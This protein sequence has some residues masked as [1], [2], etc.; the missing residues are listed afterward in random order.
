MSVPRGKIIDPNDNKRH[1]SSSSKASNINVTID[2]FLN[3]LLF[4]EPIPTIETL[5]VLFEFMLEEPCKVTALLKEPERI[6]TGLFC[7]NLIEGDSD[8]EDY[9]KPRIKNPRVI[10]IFFQILPRCC[11]LGQKFVLN[12]FLHLLSGRASL[13]NISVCSQIE[14]P[15][16]ELVLDLFHCITDEVQII[17]VKLLQTL[18]KYY[19]S[20]GQL[21]QLFQKLH[22]SKDCRPGC[23]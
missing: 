21:K 22:S 20:V 13:I 7:S 5:G 19:F 23:V 14:R 11:E 2:D 6:D 3:A 17:N 16:V 18:G 12:T 10:P 4:M 8:N 1:L 15:M 9:D